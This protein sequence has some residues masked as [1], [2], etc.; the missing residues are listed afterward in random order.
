MT[1]TDGYDGWRKS[2]GR[3][4]ERISRSLKHMEKFKTLDKAARKVVEDT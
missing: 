3:V 2:W 1:K 4:V